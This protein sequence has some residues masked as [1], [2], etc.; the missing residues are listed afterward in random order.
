MKLRSKD[1]VGFNKNTQD[2]AISNKLEDSR[3]S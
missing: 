3:Q 2:T 1:N